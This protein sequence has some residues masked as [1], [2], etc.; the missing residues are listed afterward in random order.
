M[1]AIMQSHLE[2][3]L[4]IAEVCR[5][6]NVEDST[7]RRLFRAQLKETPVAYYTRLRLERART[8]LRYS[9]L[10]VAEIAAAVGFADTPSFSHAFRRIFG[11]P[12]SQARADFSG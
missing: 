1:V 5:R 9:H 2:S 7:A 10:S 11:L 12:P 3:P 8:L 6:A 4:A